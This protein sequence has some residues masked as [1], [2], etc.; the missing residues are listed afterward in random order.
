MPKIAHHHTLKQKRKLRVSGKM[1]GTAE[2]P[3]VAVF[4]SNQH[5]VLQAIDDVAEKTVAS[6]SDLGKTKVKGT[7]TERSVAVTKLLVAG[8]KKAEISAVVFD[9]GSY[10]YHGRVKAVAETLRQ[11]GITV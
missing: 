6:A 9:R 1:N 8:L 7:K 10:R 2:R 11:E 4:R 5:I 3:R